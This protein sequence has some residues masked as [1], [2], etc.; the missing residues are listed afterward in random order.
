[1]PGAEQ[2]AH[3]ASVFS[4]LDFWRLRPAPDLLVSQPGV[5]AA[6]RFIAAAASDA[7][8]LIVAYTP[9]A[10]VIELKAALV[11]QGRSTWHD[12]RTGARLNARGVRAESA[13]RFETPAAG[14]W[15][16]VIGR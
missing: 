12:P 3:V 9:E 7:R 5:E 4:E 14:D 11:P 15:L 10:G 2:M 1:M 16:L 6:S 8:D 13:T